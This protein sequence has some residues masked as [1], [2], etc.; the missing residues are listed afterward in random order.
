MWL[1]GSFDSSFQLHD[2]VAGDALGSAVL[3][4]PTLFARRYFFKF[5]KPPAAF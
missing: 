5:F 2:C 4:A 1:I 3:L